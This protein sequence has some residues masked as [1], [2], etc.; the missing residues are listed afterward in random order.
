MPISYSVYT[1]YK[2]KR[3][4]GKVRK[5]MLEIIQKLCK[6]K[7]IEIIAGAMYSVYIHKGDGIAFQASLAARPLLGPKQTTT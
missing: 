6:Y 2:Q 7:K 4:L 5:E 3:I 1:K